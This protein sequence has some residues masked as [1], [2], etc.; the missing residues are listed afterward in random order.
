MSFLSMVFVLPVENFDQCIDILKLS[1][2]KVT[3][4]YVNTID[5]FVAGVNLGHDEYY[6]IEVND[7]T[8]EEKDR[9]FSMFTDGY[10]RADQPLAA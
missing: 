2:K 5:S 1:D 4:E 10:V 9:L 7:F 8:I 3:F 6:L